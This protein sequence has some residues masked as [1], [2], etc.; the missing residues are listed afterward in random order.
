MDIVIGIFY[1][2]CIG[3]HALMKIFVN[4]LYLGLHI[5]FGARN[6]GFDP[7]VITEIFFSKVASSLC[8]SH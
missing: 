4:I 7:Q 8:C 2:N 5:Y 3:L 6:Y 1:H